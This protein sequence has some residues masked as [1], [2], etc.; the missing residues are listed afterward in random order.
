MIA[1][2]PWWQSLQAM[3]TGYADFILTTTS[4]LHSDVQR[5]AAGL[6]IQIAPA[7]VVAHSL[8]AGDIEQPLLFAAYWS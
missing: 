3:L 7:M 4:E 8:K 6:Q 1:M 2:Q 5:Q